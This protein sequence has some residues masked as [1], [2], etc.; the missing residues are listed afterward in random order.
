MK[1]LSSTDVL[2]ARA[3]DSPSSVNGYDVYINSLSRTSVNNSLVCSL[4]LLT[5]NKIIVS[6]FK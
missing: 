4:A 3:M 1:G 5:S 2:S 6:T